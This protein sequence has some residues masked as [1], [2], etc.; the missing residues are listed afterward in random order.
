[1]SLEFNKVAAAVLVTGIVVMV[2]GMIA[3]TVVH[4][5]HLEKKAYIVA[6]A[7]E[8]PQAGEAA[9]AKAEILP[10]APLMAAASVD[11]GKDVAKKCVTC[12]SFDKDGPNKVGPNL[13]NIVGAAHGKKPGY[14][15]SSAIAELPGNWDYEALSHFLASPKTYAKGTKMSFAGLQKPEDRANVI[16]YLRSLSDAPKPLP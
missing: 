5:P 16:A 3:E 4:E 1:M 7:E 2:S 6:G 15:Y 9:P 12:H 11:A 13:W 14:T 10:I 8:T